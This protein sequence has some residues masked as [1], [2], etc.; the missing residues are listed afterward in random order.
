[1]I[2]SEPLAR[3]DYAVIVDAD[4]LQPATDFDS[5][6]L[7]ALAVHFGT[8]RLIDNMLIP[9]RSLCSQR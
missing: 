7:A 6:T 1:M 9:S 2:V 4:S 5:P 8:T 3:L